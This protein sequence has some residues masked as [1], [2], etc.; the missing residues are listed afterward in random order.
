MV[1]EKAWARD[2]FK[3]GDVV[4]RRDGKNFSNGGRFNT[5]REPTPYETC[6]SPD[7]VWVKFGWV[8]AGQV[9]LALKSL[10]DWDAKAGDIFVYHLDNSQKP[11]GNPIVIVG[12]EGEIY[13]GKE[14]DGET[15][16]SLV[17]YQPC[18]A[19]VERAKEV[20]AEQ[21]AETK[22]DGG[23]A[24]QELLE[25][26]KYQ[27]GELIR[28]KASTT[29]PDTLGQPFGGLTGTGYIQGWFKN[30]LYYLHH[31]IWIY[32]YGKLPEGI[33]DHINRDKTD[34]RIENLREASKQQ[35]SWNRSG[36]TGAVSQFKGVSRKR[37]KW[38]ARIV[39]DGVEHNLGVFETEIAA[40]L[41]YK[42][43]SRL[44]QGEYS[45][46]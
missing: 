7:I 27:D 41:A 11:S 40:G 33:I 15:V 44:L 2:K 10:R 4:K 13:Q 26:F 35:N 43:A 18:W 21:T 14:V 23:P 34:N 37:D 30:K 42:Q 22:P 45:I 1:K 3:V 36:D 20:I 29:R 17:S 5:I 19:L 39:V 8:G 9:E 12:K 28:I 32:H 16:T 24:Q 46:D 38:R 31:L 6:E 25:H